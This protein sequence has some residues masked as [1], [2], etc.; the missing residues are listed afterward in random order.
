MENQEWRER[1]AN[2]FGNFGLYG[3]GDFGTHVD[4][5]EA[6]QEFLESELLAVAKEMAEFIM[7]NG[8][9]GGNWRRLIKEFISKLEGV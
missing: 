5:F 8:H 7:M 2:K 6:V 4:Q 9:G 3:K 1:L